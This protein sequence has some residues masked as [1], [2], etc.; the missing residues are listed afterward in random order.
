MIAIK[1]PNKCAEEKRAIDYLEGLDTYTEVLANAGYAC[2]LSGKW[3]LGNSAVPQHGFKNWFS[4][5]RG[6]CSNGRWNIWRSL[7]S[8]PAP[9]ILVCIIQRRTHHGTRKGDNL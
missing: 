9:F 5:A 2:A 3:H 7:R 4:I 8:R 1:T 6:G